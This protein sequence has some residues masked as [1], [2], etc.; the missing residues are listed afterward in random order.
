VFCDAGGGRLPFG[1]DNT[2]IPG[3]GAAYLSLKLPV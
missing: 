3:S 1:L 2:F